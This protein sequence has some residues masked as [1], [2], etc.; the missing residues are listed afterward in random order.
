MGAIFTRTSA[1]NGSTAV[2]W[3]LWEVPRRSGTSVRRWCI[4][5]L[6][7]TVMVFWPSASARISVFSQTPRVG[8]SG[9][10]GHF[11]TSALYGQVSDAVPWRAVTN[12]TAWM[13]PAAH[14]AW[15]RGWFT[16]LR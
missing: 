9:V 4:N 8:V 12:G 3:A 14:R 11:P 15:L 1:R 13:S 5:L 2:S 16:T 6:C 10:A 7:L